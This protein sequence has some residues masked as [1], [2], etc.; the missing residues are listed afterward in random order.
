MQEFGSP[1]DAPF[2]QDRAARKARAPQ[3]TLLRAASLAHAWGIPLGDDPSRLPT[4]IVVGSKGKG[5]AATYASAT[6]GAVGLRVGTLTSPGYLSNRERIRVNGTML[7]QSSYH[8]LSAA[9]SG[10]I[11]RE[12]DRLPDMGYL[13]PTGLYTLAAMH[14]FR[15]R[16]CD[17]VVL[18]AG[19]GGSTD[20]VSLFTPDVVAFMTV[21]GEHLGIL[22]STTLE[23][24]EN[25]AGVIRKATHTVVCAPQREEEIRKLV[26]R[27]AGTAQ[28]VDVSFQ[29]H[30][31]PH[32]PGLIGIN[33]EVGIAAGRALL[34]K[35]FGCE[36]AAEKLV[37][38]VSS[39]VLPGRRSVHRT[40]THVIGCDSAIDGI[41]AGDAL[42]WFRKEVGEPD[43]ILV[44]I[45]DGKDW[46]GVEQACSGYRTEV[47]RARNPY[48][49][50]SRWEGTLPTIDDGILGTPGLERILALG[51][52]SFIGDV[53]DVLGVDCRS[54]WKH[55][56]Q[57]LATPAPS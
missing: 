41:G 27:K 11:A 48:L 16:H 3:R 51:T 56:G 45:P 23:I 29:E 20:E 18:E 32:A 5:T 57:R 38:V 43:C 31:L 7:T 54:L 24:A 25:K 34:R 37:E 39:V 21:F 46:A 22:G 2:F 13:A 36:I 30:Q 9:L 4:I 35:N 17:A 53:L 50:Y 55:P 44:S 49:H 10:L 1:D 19:M 15:E 26:G 6:L 8:E 40:S 28:V 52:I 33:A 47:L 14:H 42:A 12:E